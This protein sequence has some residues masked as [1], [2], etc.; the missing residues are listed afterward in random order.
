MASELTHSYKT[1]KGSKRTPKEAK[2]III[3]LIQGGSTVEA[4]CKGAGKSIKSYE[5]YR[6]TD[7]QFK[8]AIDLVRKMQARDGADLGDEADISFEDFRTKYLMS[9]TFPH[10]LNMTDLLDG[11]EP[12]WLHPAM[13]YEQGEP[14][15][16]LINIPPDHAKSMTVS[17]DYLTYRICTDPNVRIKVVSKTQTMACE[18]LYAIKQRLTNPIWA[19]LQARFAPP[20]GWKATAEKWTSTEIYLQ[21]NSAEKDPTIQALGIGGQIYGARADLIILDDCVTLSNAGEYEKQMRWIQQDCVTRLGP[22]SKLFVVGTRV[23]PIDLYKVLRDGK[24]YPE[25]TSPWTYLSMPALLE[26]NDDP[27]LAVTLWPKSDRPWLGDKVPAD[28]DG[29]FPRWDMAHL[30]KRRAAIDARTWA[31]VY[32]QQ[33]VSSDATFNREAV[34]GSINGMRAPGILIKGAPGHPAIEGELF[35]V[36]SMDPAM[37]GDT[38]TIAYAG[39]VKTK[40]RYVLEA[41]MMTAPTPAKIREIIHDWTI[42]YQP[43]VWVIEKNAFQLFLTQDEE[44]NK[45]FASRGI[46]MVDHYTG[47]NKMDSEYGVASMAGL[48]GNVDSEGKHLGDNLINLPRTSDESTKGLVEQLV[49]WTPDS[50][51]KQDGPMALWFAETQMRNYL[52]QTASYQMSKVTNPFVTRGQMAKRQIVNIDEWERI[53]NATAANG[54]YVNASNH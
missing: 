28:A 17:I 50:R 45:F 54:G 14:E 29:L 7:S 36:C 15:Y 40:K 38:F 9:Q 18:Y 41:S 24:R 6:S 37:S 27:D 2:Q 10:Q 22:F 48:F 11:K 34:Q 1:A 51:N 23:D 35:V 16:V 42:K 30:R 49:T 47:R 20:E 25:G 32:Q 3:E 19:D 46:R 26:A 4:A 31:M 21:R 43:K 12:R 53:K 33:D 52:N 5:Y 39:D 13:V 8:D 44:I